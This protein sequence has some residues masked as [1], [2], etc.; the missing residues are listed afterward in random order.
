MDVVLSRDRK[1]SFPSGRIAR[2]GY[3]LRKMFSG[4]WKYRYVPMTF[5]ERFRHSLRLHLE[6]PELV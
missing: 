3:K 2:I 1:L 6:R 4:S 5:R